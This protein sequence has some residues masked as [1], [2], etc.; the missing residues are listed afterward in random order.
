MSNSQHYKYNRGKVSLE[1]VVD[2]MDGIKMFES[3]RKAVIGYFVNGKTVKD[4]NV[5]T[6]ILMPV[7]REVNGNIIYN[8]SYMRRFLSTNEFSP[9]RYVA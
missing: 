4:L 1:E 6:S 8:S 2:A 9:R 5:N 3:I 7:L